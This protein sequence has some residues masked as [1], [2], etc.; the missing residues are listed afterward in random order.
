[1][2][3]WYFHFSE[4]VF[5]KETIML[6]VEITRSQNGISISFFTGRGKV[7]QIAKA[8]EGSMIFTWNYMRLVLPPGHLTLSLSAPSAAA[9]NL[10]WERQ[11]SKSLKLICLTSISYH[12]VLFSLSI[13]NVS[14][15]KSLISMKC[16]PRCTH[17][18]PHCLDLIFNVWQYLDQNSFAELSKKITLSDVAVW[19][20]NLPPHSC[21]NRKRTQKL[22]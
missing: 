4:P 15:R 16:Y 11:R 3:N 20:L 8:V 6:G 12:I 18:T 10:D 9:T 19:R 1:M 13:K 22:C 14:R 2:P 21:Y 5:N 17:W 7:K